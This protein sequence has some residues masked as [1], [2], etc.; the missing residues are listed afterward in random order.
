MK[1]HALSLRLL[2]V[3]AAL[4][5]STGFAQN[6]APKKPAISVPPLSPASTL[7]QRVG[8]TDIEIVYA[9]PSLRGRKIFG[10]W[11]PYGEVWRTGANNATKV[12][13]STPVRFSGKELPAGTYALY[14]IPGEKEWTIIF[15]K[16][17]GD[18]GAYSYKQENDVLRVTAKP[19][20]LPQPVETFTIDINDIKTESATL[21]LSWENVRVPVPFQFDVISK[22][23]AQIEAAMN[24]GQKLEPGA[25]YSAAVFYL[26]N[27]LDLN[28]ARGWIEEATKGE[29]PRFFMLYQKARILA[30][31]GDKTGATAAAQQ[32]IA[33]AQKEGGPV[34]VEYRR[35]NEELLATL[36]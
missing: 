18:W 1:S 28:K 13:F 3:S 35:R 15:N 9:R 31:L 2:A 5:A 36:K 26:E 22:V 23:N 33:A 11:E 27:G 32:S 4:L 25:Y 24:S 29:N 30:K 16:A 14:S 10:A 12:T 8:F 21:N 7:K 19:I 34:A 17:S 6:A 20:K